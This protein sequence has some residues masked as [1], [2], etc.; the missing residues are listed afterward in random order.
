MIFLAHCPDKVGLIAQVT[1]FFAEENLNILQ[2]EQHTERKR[3]FIRIEGEEMNPSQPITSWE[4]KFK[5]L[6]EELEMEYKFHEPQERIK[7]AIFCSKT[8]PCPLEILA[9]QLSGNMHIDIQC[10]ISNH[11]TI[12]GIA[13]RLDVPFYY[14][15]TPNDNKSYEAKQLQLVKAFN[16]DLIVLARYMKVLSEHF[17]KQAP[18]PIIN[19]HHSFLPSFAGGNPYGEAYDRGVKLIGA[20]A[21]FV[22]KDLDEGPIINQ[23]VMPVDHEY[24]V[25]ELKKTGANIE[26]QVFAQAVQK[27]SEHKIIEWEGRTVVFH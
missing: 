3:F 22:T 21:H 11:R 24:S 4:R 25:E 20:T 12:E 13:E 10:V 9:R 18:A 17:L 1:N 6:G 27:F 5:L 23:N 26:K 8:L 2:L 16:V 7:I 19:I 14:I 15:A